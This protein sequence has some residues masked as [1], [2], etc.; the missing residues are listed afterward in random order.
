M[1]TFLEYYRNKNILYITFKVHF[2]LS[3]ILWTFIQVLDVSIVCSS[4]LLSSIPWCICI[5][6]CCTSLSITIWAAFGFR[7]LQI[8]LL[9]IIMYSF[10]V[11]IKFHFWVFF[12]LLTICWYLLKLSY[13][14]FV[15]M[16]FR[17]FLVLIWVRWLFADL[18]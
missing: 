1:L 10:C 9:K 8:N 11:N 4:L 12:N 18:L 17:T 16:L 14:I 15:L 6:G 7:L 13:Y 2:G 3:F 5:I